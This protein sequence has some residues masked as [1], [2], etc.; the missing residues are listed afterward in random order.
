MLQ[1]S[2][3]FAPTQGL[4]LGVCV[5]A[6]LCDCDGNDDVY[7]SYLPFLSCVHG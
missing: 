5:T 3:S 7:V 4:M 6:V 2:T 1:L